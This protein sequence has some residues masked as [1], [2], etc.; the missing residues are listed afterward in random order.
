[1]SASD[2]DVVIAG[3]GPSG[4]ATALFLW[5]AFSG[6]SPGG[7][8][9]GIGPH[10]PRI[11]LIDKAAFPREKIC[12]GAIG[13]RADK[14]LAAIGVEVRCPS[15]EVRGLGVVTGEGRLVE[16]HPRPIGR[17]VRRREFDDA[18]LEQVRA[19]G[20]EVKTGVAFHGFERRRGGIVVQTSAGAITAKCLVGA[21]GVGSRVRRELGL[22][23]GNIY[24]QA[25]E[26]DTVWCDAD[27][28]ERDDDDVLWF[29]LRDRRYPGYG[30][31]FPTVLGGESMVCRGIYRVTHGPCALSEQGPDVSSLLVEE[32]ARLGLAE[33]GPFKRFAERGLAAHEATAQARVM[34]VGEAAGIDPVLGEGIAQAILYGRAAGGFLAKCLARGDFS[35]AGW[36]RTLARSR[37]GVDLTARRFALPHVYGASRPMLERLVASSPA[38]ARAGL[39]YFAGEH[40]PHVELLRAMADGVGV[41]MGR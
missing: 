41:L 40:V 7:T 15:V 35:F 24:A 36:S 23:R 21:D 9:R 31:S 22:G 25:I 39:H 27:A 34:L 11:L 32:L 6:V 5:A 18:F 20:I 12:A 26:T 1:M 4:C 8:A 29:D 13:G 16:K 10:P 30:W 3:G 33:D 14:A 17:V 19:R 2:C 38:L 37:V 28:R